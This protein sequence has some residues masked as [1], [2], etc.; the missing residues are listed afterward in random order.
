MSR[1]WPIAFHI[2]RNYPIFSE[3]DHWD[4]SKEKGLL[5]V[6]DKLIPYD[7]SREKLL[8][9]GIGEDK[10]DSETVTI[11]ELVRSLVPE[12]HSLVLATEEELRQ[13]LPSDLPIILRLDE[14]H[15]PDLIEDEVPSKNEAFQMIAD[16]LVFGDATYYKPTQ[17]PNTHWSNWLESGTL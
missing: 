1:K 2:K 14:W 13:I 17:P 7:V 11:T 8:Q 5:R 15:H 6:R 12:H 4:V 10:W 16:V 3:E 9:R